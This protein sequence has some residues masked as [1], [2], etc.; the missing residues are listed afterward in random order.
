MGSGAEYSYGDAAAHRI[1][2]AVF[3]T[4]AT[5]SCGDR[6]GLLRPG[7]PRPGPALGACGRGQGDQALVG[8]GRR[9]GRALPARGAAAR[10]CQRSRGRADLRLRRGRGGSLLRRRAR[11]GREPRRP[12]AA[13]AARAEE[14]RAVAEQLCGA[15]AGAHRRGCCTATS[16]RPTCC[17]AR[18]AGS[19]SATSASRAS[20]RAPRRRPRRPSRARLYMSPE[21]ARGLP[22]TA[23]TDVYS[24]GVVLYEM[25]AGEPPFAH[26]SVV[27]LGLRH[28][29]DA[30]PPLPAE[31]APRRCARGREGDGQGAG[32]ALRDGGAMAA[33]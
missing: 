20:P 21:Q 31:R 25:L 27:E 30:P 14:A 3:S 23:A 22:T 18:T 5:S 24:A 15:L 26:G 19:G 17:S 13:R 4:A 6:G 2:P 9:L 16:S 12:P 11:R 8:R 28:L 29:Q 1:S 7:L 10:A 33:R 32:R